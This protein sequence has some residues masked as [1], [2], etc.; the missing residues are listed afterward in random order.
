M[1]EIAT[2]RDGQFI[3]FLRDN[4]QQSIEV[5]IVVGYMTPEG[6]FLIRETIESC[7]HR[8]GQ[9]K[10]L[11][12]SVFDGINYE[13]CLEFE[14]KWGGL[15]RFF[16]STHPNTLVHGKLY[17]MKKSQNQAIVAIGSSNLTQQGMLFNHE[18]NALIQ[19]EQN[20]AEFADIQK[21]INNV[22]EF[23]RP[24]SEQCEK[25]SERVDNVAAEVLRLDRA[26]S[27][28]LVEIAEEVFSNISPLTVEAWTEEIEEM[29]KRFNE[30]LTQEALFESDEW[31]GE[32]F[33][34]GFMMTDI[35]AVTESKHTDLWQRIKATPTDRLK[36]AMF[37]MVQAA[38]RGE[39][40]AEVLTK[41]RIDNVIGV[42]IAS[43]ILH[44]TFP[45]TYVI[46]NK[47]SEWG[48]AF[49]LDKGAGSEY[50]HEM[51]YSDFIQY[52]NAVYEIFSA[53][54]RNRGC[55][56]NDSYRY[57]IC[58][59]L[60]WEISENPRHQELM[61]FYNQSMRVKQW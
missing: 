51:T 37:K 42:S 27:E 54:L 2:S 49:I 20:S 15:C 44:K 29:S 31:R 32:K 35:W 23:S 28:R 26:S 7:L 45:T 33:K 48:L 5:N 55:N 30:I 12:G 13:R 38:E 53:W 19:L 36:T 3:C 1:I 6:F 24:L 43:E 17:V 25:Y 39:P 59:R 57:Y 21:Y 9:I 14:K 11:I 47:R 34:S 16:V 41:G 22:F 52:L 56:P 10:I 40:P 60:F 46:K 18:I 58:D 4:I 61:K 8:K 50:A